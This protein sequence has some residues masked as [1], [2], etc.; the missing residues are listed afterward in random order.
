MLKTMDDRR[1]TIAL[2]AVLLAGAALRLVALGR[3]S[4]W[5]DELY[6]VQ[7][8]PR[9]TQYF[10]RIPL[11]QHPP[12]YYLLIQQ[13]LHWG[14]SEFWLRLP[15]AVAGLL[16][17]PLL[18]WV[19]LA[20]GRPRVG[21]LAAGLL[22]GSPI[23]VWYSR[24]ARMYGL[25][26]LWWALALL[27]YA[28]LWRRGRW[29]DAAGLAIA[30]LAGLYTAY[31]TFALWL[32]GGAFFL[33][34]WLL[35]EKREWRL[36]GRWLAAQVVVA[37][38]LAFWWPFLAQQLASRMEFH[39]AGFRLTLA[40]TLGLGLAAGLLFVGLLLE[41]GLLLAARPGLVA[42][43]RR[44]AGPA[45]VAILLLFVL[46]TVLGATPRGL[47]PRRQLLVFWPPAVLLAAWAVA[48]FGRWRWLGLSL[49]AL[50][51]V[52][53][54]FMAFGPAYEDWRGAVG[55]MSQQVQPGDQ[56][57]FSPSWSSLAF[58]YYYQ[59]PADFKK[60]TLGRVQE[61]TAPPG[62]RVWLIINNH[63]ALLEANRPVQGWLE[64]QGEPE[65]VYSFPR[66]LFV[67]EYQ[68]P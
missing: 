66:Y 14:Q 9:A 62:S 7:V 68:N 15:S 47:S 49:A 30:L 35:R 51:C 20:L 25:V 67:L 10:Q 63:P 55:L 60:L 54:A 21:L 41:A 22:A 2:L 58:T 32:G 11:D 46:A 53:A 4:L 48:R 39:W 8:A 45:A 13:W 5:T 43:L 33:F 64:Q 16:A 57:L 40:Q 1:W 42:W 38:G 65:A 19:G 50:S 18:G 24:E 26:F 12:L 27:F 61:A 36:L 52:L 59:G 56:V 6:T 31:P 28:R 44:W 29:A 17:V 37:A 3:W 23:H 34:F